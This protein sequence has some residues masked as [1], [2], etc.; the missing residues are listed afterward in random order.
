MHVVKMYKIASK[1]VHTLHVQELNE[2]MKMS[3][4]KGFIDISRKVMNNY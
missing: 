1:H 4:G 2:F 3:M